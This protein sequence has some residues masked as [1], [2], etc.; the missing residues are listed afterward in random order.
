MGHAV[1]RYGFDRRPGFE[2]YTLQRLGVQRRVELSTTTPA[3]LGPLIVGTQR[4]ATVPE[5]LALKQKQFL[6]LKLFKPPLDLPP[7]RIVAQWHKTREGDGATR[8]L[9]DLIV[10]TAKAMGYPV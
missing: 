2:Q 6:P 4:I 7:L 9:R 1:T 3:L 10:E 5:R 8:W